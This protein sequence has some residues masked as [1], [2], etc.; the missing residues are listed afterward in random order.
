[1]AALTER[2]ENS[3]ALLAAE[4]G[5]PRL[6]PREGRPGTVVFQQGA[7]EATRMGGR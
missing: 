1:M 6:G 7:E 2:R 5:S 4:A 3:A